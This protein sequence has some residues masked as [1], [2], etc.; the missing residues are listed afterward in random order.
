MA[1]EQRAEAIRWQYGLAFGS[2]RLARVYLEAC[3]QGTVEEGTGERGSLLLSCRLL[4]SH[5]HALVAECC[6]GM[7]LSSAQLLLL[8]RRYTH[9]NRYCV[10][11]E[12][13]LSNTRTVTL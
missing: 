5:V 3:G 4:P 7:S 1:L 8:A 6:V 10:T 9:Q 12:P 13:L 2:D 11:P